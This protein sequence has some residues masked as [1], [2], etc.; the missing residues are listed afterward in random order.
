MATDWSGTTM[1]DTTK[2]P[3]LDPKLLLQ[4][5]EAQRLLYKTE[6]IPGGNAGPW[7]RVW[8]EYDVGSYSVAA[9]RDGSKVVS[10]HTDP[11][12]PE[13]VLDLARRCGV[14]LDIVFGV[15]VHK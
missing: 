15:K 8:E 4:E 10:V 13:M 9:F 2:T 14:L 7:L 1:S 11:R 12:R 5:A 3:E 6:R